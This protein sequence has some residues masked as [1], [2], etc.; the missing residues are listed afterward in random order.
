MSDLAGGLAQ[1]AN[2]AP[3]APAASPAPETPSTPSQPASST[4]PVSLADHFRQIEETPPSDAPPTPEAPAPA[5][6]T[7]EPP[8]VDATAE[9]TAGPIPFE[10]HKAVLES[11][12]KK[13]AEE[14]VQQ[15]QQQYGEAI[16]FATAFNADP[17]ATAVGL[18]DRLQTHPEYGPQLKSYAARVLSQ[19]RQQQPPADPEPQA[20]VVFKYEDGSEGRTFSD[21][22]LR[23]W[24]E[25]NT[26]QM[27]QQLTQ[28]LAPVMQIAQREKA[29]QAKQQYVAQVTDS[30]RPFAEEI[31]AMPGFAEHRDEILT[32]QRELFD[33]SSRSGQAVDPMQL[34]LRAY[35][36][37]VPAKLQQQQQQQLVTSAM[38]KAAGR[39]AN[40][41]AVVASPPPTP[42]SLTDAFAQVGLR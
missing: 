13:A 18:M 15:F 40:P 14:A 3:S 22:Q 10:R 7:E 33:Q 20:D 36:E 9:E 4:A 27:R 25:W 29:E 5:P 1:A 30:Y 28:E 12:R 34:V 39:D 23:K 38:A 42:K 26:K 24:Q 37:I 6:A 35:R 16:Q 17:V 21:A 8:K 11:T 41:A 2:T 31:M 19:R 32:R